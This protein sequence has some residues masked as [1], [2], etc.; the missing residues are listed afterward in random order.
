MVESKEIG[1]N[2][3]YV[4]S[5]S[6]L[7]R[8]NAFRYSLNAM[9]ELGLALNAQGGIRSVV[10]MMG[11]SGGPRILHRAILP[12]PYFGRFAMGH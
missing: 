8:R 10:D 9:E 2:V 3:Y 6:Y 11:R 1:R 7:P 5:F 12:P 4:L